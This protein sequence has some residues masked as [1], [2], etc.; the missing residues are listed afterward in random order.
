M[1]LIGSAPDGVPAL[2]YVGSP[3]GFVVGGLPGRAASV[4]VGSTTTGSAGSAAVVT[5][6]GSANAAVLNFTVPR[7]TAVSVGST[8][9]GL[10]GSSASVTNSGTVDAAVLNFTIPRGD[11]GPQGAPGTP[12][13]VTI[14]GLGDSTTISRL[15]VTTAAGGVA[16]AD[17]A[18]TFAKVATLF[19]PNQGIIT[20]LLSCTSDQSVSPETAVFQAT[21]R[22]NSGAAAPT[23]IVSMLSKGGPVAQHIGADAFKLVS[24]APAGDG[25][26]T[27]ELWMKKSS[28]YGR[29]G[30]Y[31]LSRKTDGASSA[32]TYH[33]NAAWQQATPTNTYE[34][35]SNGVTAFGQKVATLNDLSTTGGNLVPNGSFTLDGFKLGG[36]FT[37]TSISTEQARS[38]TRSLK[39][40]GYQWPNLTVDR[41]PCTGSEVVYA[42]AWVR[43]HTDNV[44]NANNV[45][46]QVN[47]YRAD[48]TAT[49]PGAV[50]VPGGL[51]SGTGLNGVWSKLSGYVT[52]PSDAAF[53]E[54]YVITP[55]NAGSNIYYWD[56]VYAA[57]VRVPENTVTTTGAQALTNKTLTSPTLTNPAVNSIKDTNGNTSVQIAATAS[58]VNYVSVVNAAAGGAINVYADGA[59]AT[60]PLAIHTKGAGSITLRSNI[61][62]AGLQVDPV[63]SG[64]NFL[65]VSSAVTGSAPTLTAMGADANVSLKLQCKGTAPMSLAAGNTNNML[66]LYPPAGAVNNYF[67]IQTASTGATPSFGAIGSDAN[68]SMNLTTQGTGTV[69]A[70]GVPVVTTTGSQ[71]LTNKTLSGAKCAGLNDPTYNAPALTINPAQANPTSFIEIRPATS[72][73]QIRALG[74]LT[75]ISLALYSKGSGTVRVCA[76]SGSF[77]PTLQADNGQVDCSLNLKSNGAGTVQ[78]NGNPVGVKV[79]VPATAT[80]TGVVGQWAADASW[81]YV[82]TATNTWR[83][84]ALSTW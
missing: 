31:E 64:V 17:G 61:Y 16:A 15:A 72:V 32:A 60:V 11:V 58:A 23:L 1:R 14:T 10:P 51:N 63:A 54:V 73:P 82:C 5:N 76:D 57:K 18:N 43:G 74:S 12:G 33:A 77:T 52:L 44:A 34:A 47:S 22:S 37:N 20:V 75:D 84:T 26:V 53:F 42:E 4:E 68:V 8:S 6:S 38:G 27:A 48:G 65:N 62:G 67:N 49:S 79:A 66:T 9:T 41:I 35:F 3:E 70:N 19:V 40:V 56:D 21:L 13:A 7:G 29:F 45:Y 28:A 46:L 81:H 30:L 25:S 59:S 50:A 24:G 80:S 39:T 36:A 71:V 2:S 83:R 78:A 69:Q 55:S